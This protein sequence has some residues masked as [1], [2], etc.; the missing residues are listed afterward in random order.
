MRGLRRSGAVAAPTSARRPGTGGL[1]GLRG[2]EMA[3]VCGYRS[4]AR[5]VDRCAA[6]WRVACDCR[7]SPASICRLAAA[8]RY[9]HCRWHYRRRCQWHARDDALPHPRQSSTHTTSALLLRRFSSSWSRLSA[10]GVLWCGRCF[11]RLSPDHRS[12]DS[13]VYQYAP[14]PP[15]VKAAAAC[16][17]R[18]SPLG[19]GLVTGASRVGVAVAATTRCRS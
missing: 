2:E 12:Q 13:G 18:A 10:H 9:R 8:P 5:P 15:L 3:C 4:P 14:P 7:L 1:G 17:G 11:G 6:P 19:R 16:A